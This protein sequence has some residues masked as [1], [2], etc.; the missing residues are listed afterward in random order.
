MNRE[1]SDLLHV[2]RTVCGEAGRKNPIALHE[3]K[4]NDSITKE[5]VN[6]AES[7]WV[8]SAGEWVKV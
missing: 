4:L 6:A 3:P 8:S 2:L 5:Y 7:G 1:T